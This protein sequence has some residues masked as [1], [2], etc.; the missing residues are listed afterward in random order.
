VGNKKVPRG[1]GTKKETIRKIFHWFQ[2]R[3]ALPAVVEIQRGEPCGSIVFIS[4]GLLKINK[5]GD[6]HSNDDRRKQNQYLSP[7][8]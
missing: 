4:S 8:L 5:N 2:L 6:Q 1:G 3:P 7:P